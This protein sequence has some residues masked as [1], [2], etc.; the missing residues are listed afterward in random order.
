MAYMEMFGN[1]SHTMH[2][3]SEFVRH[4]V[5]TCNLN[6]HSSSVDQFTTTTSTTTTNSGSC[7][8]SSQ[9]QNSRFIS[10]SKTMR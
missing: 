2:N 6:H 4:S 9:Q 5:H 10:H 3:N 8:I 7:N 1:C